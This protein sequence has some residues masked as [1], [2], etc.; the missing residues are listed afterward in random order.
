MLNRLHLAQIGF[1]FRDRGVP[2]TRT[3]I[4]WASSLRA[5][6]TPLTGIVL[7]AT[8]AGQ[9]PRELDRSARRDLAATLRRAGLHLGALDLFIPVEHYASPAQGDRARAALLAAIDLAREIA[10]LTQSPEAIVCT[11]FPPP[12]ESGGLVESLLGSIREHAAEVDVR[13]ADAA[14][15]STRP[16]IERSVEVARCLMA[17][18]DPVSQLTASC[19]LR[20]SDAA[21]G[22]RVPLGR[23]DAD[24]RA[25]AGSWAVLGGQRPPILDLRGLTDAEAAVA[26]AIASWSRAAAI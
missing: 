12:T 1:C 20:L 17:G 16:G 22:K 15:G 6:A 10:T 2:E 19:I 24:T 9:R 7:D 11:E 8:R 13:L 4:E 26:D 3:L 5:A 14:P 21:A 23:G 18:T 25:I